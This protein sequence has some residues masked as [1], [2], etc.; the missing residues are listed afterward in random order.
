MITIGS[1][2]ITGRDNNPRRR[3]SG[4]PLSGMTAPWRLTAGRAPIAQFCTHQEGLRRAPAIAP[5]E[6]GGY[7]KPV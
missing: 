1:N 4:H 7:L 2:G 3:H 5:N 6:R